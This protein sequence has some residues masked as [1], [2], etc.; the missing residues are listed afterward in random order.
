MTSVKPG[1]LP[2]AVLAKELGHLWKPHADLVRRVGVG[3]DDER[4][5]ELDRLR[6]NR[7]RRVRLRC[8]QLTVP[9]TGRIDF[10]A[11]AGFGNRGQRGRDLGEAARGGLPARPLDDIKM[12]DEI[13]SAAA[14]GGRIKGG[15]SRC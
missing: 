14:K 9:V 6:N 13:S 8:R 11:D 4:N 1:E 12:R 10:H 2:A 3:I 5:T 15:A 7:Q